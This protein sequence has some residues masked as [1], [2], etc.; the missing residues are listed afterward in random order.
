MVSNGFELVHDD[1]QTE[2][3]TPERRKH[4]FVDDLIF[5]NICLTHAQ[6]KA[7]RP[8]TIKI[9]VSSVLSFSRT[10]VVIILNA[11]SQP[12]AHPPRVRILA[13]AILQRR[14]SVILNCFASLCSAL[15][16]LSLLSSA[17]WARLCP[18]Q[19][20]FGAFNKHRVKWVQRSGPVSGQ[21]TCPSWYKPT[22]EAA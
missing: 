2:A 21:W 5:L 17:C 6:T 4:C 11:K 9:M 20:C 18:A 8:R 7:Q 14:R 13:R 1:A 10:L 22:H 15:F 16:R 3:Q 19:L 12:A